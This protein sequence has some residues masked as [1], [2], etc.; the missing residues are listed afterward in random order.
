MGSGNSSIEARYRKILEILQANLDRPAKADRFETFSKAVSHYLQETKTS[1]PV[2]GRDVFLIAGTNGK[3]SVAK[4]LETLLN[5]NGEHV[6]LFTSPHLMDTTERIRSGGRD[7]THEEFVQI[8]DLIESYIEPYE[9]SHF[10]ILTLMMIETFFGGRVRPRVSSA[11]IEVGVGG[12]LDPTRV[13]P[14]ETAVVTRIGLDHEAILGPLPSIAREKFAIAQG[15]KR[16]VYAPPEEHAVASA[17]FEAK[18]RYRET[19]FIEVE[20]YSQSVEKN[21]D[22]PRWWIETPYGRAPLAL[23]GDRA[24]YNTS[25]ALQAYEAS[26]RSMSEVLGALRKVQWPARMEKLLFDGRKIYLSGDHNPQGVESLR[27]LLKNFEYEKLWLVIGIGKNKDVSDM[28]ERFASLPR[29]E[30]VLTLTPFRSLELSDYGKWLS[31]AKG[32]C[33]DPIEALEFAV[34][35]AGPN[36]LIV[37]TGSLYLAGDLRLKVVSRNR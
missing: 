36:D 17:V 1:W 21:G 23:L 34:K 15:A 12:R 32:A 3:G 9:L 26:R 5:A 8:Y 37:V 22:E 35:Q 16:A 10:E 7:L 25:I 30:L 6:G 13:V 24:V 27:E 4:T 29:A 31:K 28:L 2:E 14:H 20:P 18:N 33:A 11:V 19:E